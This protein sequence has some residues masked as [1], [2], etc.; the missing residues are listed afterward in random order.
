GRHALNGSAEHP[1][2]DGNGN[3]TAHPHDDM[4]FFPRGDFNGDGILDQNSRR[5]VAGW[6]R[7]L[8]FTD[9]GVLTGSDLWA[10]TRY[11]EASLNGLIDSADLTV[12]AENF[13]TKNTDIDAEGLVSV[14]HAGTKTAI[15]EGGRCA[16]SPASP[17]HLFTVPV[18]ASYYLASE[19]ISI[20]DGTNVIMRSIG[21]VEIASD[22]RGADFVVDLSL[23]EMTAVAETGN[24]DEREVDSKPDAEEVDAYLP[25]GAGGS[26][27]NSVGA[28]A[29]ANDQ[30]TFYALARAG[31]TE[32]PPPDETQPTTFSS[33]VRW[34]RSFTKDES[35]PDPTFEVKPMVL[36]LAGRG[37]NDTELSAF[38]EIVVEMRAYDVSPA[39]QPVFLYHAE[40]AGKAGIGGNPSTFRIVGQEGDLPPKTLTLEGNFAAE[41]VQEKYKGT[42]DLDGVPNGHTFEVRYR[43]FAKVLGHEAEGEAYAFIGDPLDYGTANRIAYGSWG[44]L[45]FVTGY[46]NDNAGAG[47]IA[48]HSR[49]NFYFLLYRGTNTDTAGA[50]IAIKLGQNG[51]DEMI[52][53]NPPANAG[54]DSY[55]VENRPLTQPLDVDGDGIDD[56]FELLRPAILDPVDPSD[57][58]ADAD[59]DGRTNL[60]EYLDGTDP[61]V[62][63][64]GPPQLYPALLFEATGD[65]VA[66]VN[67]DGQPDLVGYD[68]AGH[69]SVSFGQPDQSFLAPI[70]STVPNVG[71]SFSYTLARVN[72]DAFLD[73]LVVDRTANLLQVMLGDGAGSFTAGQ[74]YTAGNRP[75]RVVSGDVNGDTTP[76]AV[77]VND[78]GWMITVLLGNGDGTFQA[79]RNTDTVFAPRDVAVAR[80]NADA[81]PD[82]AVALANHTVA[83]FPGNGDGT[84][85]N[86]QAFAT[87]FA[88]QRVAAGDVNGDGLADLVTANQSG[89]SVSVLLG[90]GDGTFQ[91]K[92]DYLTGD[93][94]REFKLA[95]LD[96]DQDLDLVVGHFGA[97]YHAILRNNGGGA[98]TAQTPAFTHN[99]GN[100]LLADFNGDGLLDLLSVVGGN[101]A[102]I[103]PGLGG[104]RFDT[105]LDVIIPGLSPRAHVEQDMN[106]DGLLDIVVADQRSNVVYLLVGQGDG[107]FGVTNP[108]PVGPQVAGVVAARL[109]ADAL[110]DLAVITERPEFPSAGSSNQLHLLVANGTGGFTAQTPLSLPDRPSAVLAGDLNGD[111]RDDLAVPLFFANA[112]ALFLAQTDG[113]FTA[114]PLLDFEG[115][116]SA[117]QLR[118]L[119]GDGRAD[120]VATVSTGFASRLRVYH[121][122]PSGTLVW[123]QDLIP[124]E[125]DSVDGFTFHDFT[126]DGRADLVASVTTATGAEVVVHAATI[127]GR[128]GPRVEVLADSWR[129]GP[130]EVADVNGDGRA[131][132]VGGSTTW[133]ARSAGG[134]EPPQSY[135]LPG[136]LPMHVTDL[137]GDGRPDLITAD[138][139]SDS[140]RVL[141]HR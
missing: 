100:C 134:F 37:P 6:F 114:L 78:S 138:D 118:D 68:G 32:I 18:G 112:L 104:G 13:F 69:I 26:G 135:W 102:F 101:Q 109:N 128:F 119:N 115:Q 49:S 25:A 8:Y 81:F 139:P 133:L 98:F 99:G 88:P 79:A 97:P 93:N 71:F 141:Y 96:G 75:S 87:G 117:Y 38:A 110:P 73:A 74:H 103:S 82:L 2:L 67:N 1:L 58:L 55:I 47:H 16:F 123:V 111:G 62:A 64:G 132:L 106:L 66:D 85:R 130:L 137:N 108:V 9:L 122:N 70:V 107:R 7:D 34:Q 3:G 127:D 91:A 65:Q 40:I 42:I 84:F 124:A 27:T 125:A 113:S 121:A 10:D 92:T 30:G 89:D 60:R 33:A 126:S 36:R 51:P 56:V 77:L 95:D 35:L 43:L 80:L 72:A 24:P 5:S 83:V 131:D 14:Y 48:Y 90:N 4:F 23:V 63:D 44:E 50:P 57:A 15:P 12:S 94:P 140:I 41:Y 52:D 17:L 46:T 59:G 20:G 53:P 86:P 76:D 54:P 21:D 136:T 28:R 120:L 31:E 29:W 129:G 39:W 105:R 19:Y 11:S 116:P 22:Q 45:P 61:A